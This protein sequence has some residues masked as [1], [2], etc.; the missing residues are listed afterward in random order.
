MSSHRLVVS[1]AKRPPFEVHY[2]DPQRRLAYL[3]RKVA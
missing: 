1:P 2:L 3:V